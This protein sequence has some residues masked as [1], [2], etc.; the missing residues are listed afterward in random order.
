M[1]SA[2]VSRKPVASLMLASTTCML[3]LAACGTQ[4]PAAPAEQ[5]TASPAPGAELALEAENAVLEHTPGLET[6]AL[7]QPGG[8]TNARIISDAAARGGPNSYANART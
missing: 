3:L 8:T 2:P 1:N 6:L 5:A 7:V 4:V